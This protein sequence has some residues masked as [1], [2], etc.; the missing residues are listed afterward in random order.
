M[1]EQAKDNAMTAWRDTVMAE[2]PQRLARENQ[3]IMLLS[4]YGKCERDVTST[5]VALQKL[6]QSFLRAANPAGPHCLPTCATM[7]ISYAV[8]CMK[9]KTHGGQTAS[10]GCGKKCA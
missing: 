8:S 9:K 3:K 7:K 5:S 2:P 1:N 6:A 4:F 10:F